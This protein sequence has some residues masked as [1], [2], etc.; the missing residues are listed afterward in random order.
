MFC[1]SI[2]CSFDSPQSL[3]IVVIVVVVVVVVVWL[4]CHS[5]VH[6]SSQQ[7]GRTDHGDV[8][9]AQRKTDHGNTSRNARKK[10]KQKTRS[11]RTGG[12]EH[13]REKDPHYVP[14]RSQSNKRKQDNQVTKSQ[15]T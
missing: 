15:S 6:E 10:K 5:A 9:N 7:Q 14:P 12:Q 13:Q 4:F 3:V 8:A 1:F 2:P 11:D